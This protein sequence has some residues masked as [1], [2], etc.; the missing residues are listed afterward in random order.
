MITDSDPRVEPLA[1]HLA[2]QSN[3]WIDWN[4]TTELWKQAWRNGAKTL[5]AIADSRDN[6][7]WGIF[8]HGDDCFAIDGLVSWADTVEEAIEFIA[9]NSS[10]F[11]CEG[12]YTIRPRRIGPWI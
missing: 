6:I 12:P 1:Q 10:S 3:C 7:E 5:L 11:P 8:A 9:D 4:K 2:Y